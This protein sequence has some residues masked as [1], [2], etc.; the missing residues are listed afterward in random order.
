MVLEEIAYYIRTITEEY[1]DQNLEKFY[2][3]YLLALKKLQWG[4]QYDFKPEMINQ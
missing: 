4:D 3:K 2:V 1:H